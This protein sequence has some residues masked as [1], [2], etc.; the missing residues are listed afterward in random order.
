MIN[1]YHLGNFGI[2]RCHFLLLDISDKF[3]PEFHQLPVTQSSKQFDL[4]PQPHFCL[5]VGR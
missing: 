2:V 4:I 1:A 5:P 3:T